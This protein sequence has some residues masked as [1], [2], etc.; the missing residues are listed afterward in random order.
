M[1]LALFLLNIHAYEVRLP[2]ILK[3]PFM[4]LL[5]MISRG[6]ARD[7]ILLVNRDTVSGKPVMQERHLHSFCL[8]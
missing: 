3:N 2:L 5:H 8:T 4:E 6:F 7:L 1:A